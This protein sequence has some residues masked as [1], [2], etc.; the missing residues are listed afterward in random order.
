MFRAPKERSPWVKNTNFP[1]HPL[2]LDILGG[3]I[4]AAH[5]IWTWVWGCAPGSNPIGAFGI[6]PLKISRCG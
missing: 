3:S 5:R 1:H 2:H 6:E 4:P